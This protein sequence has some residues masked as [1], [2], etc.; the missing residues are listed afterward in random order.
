MIAYV[1]MGA[2]GS[3]EDNG[4]VLLDWHAALTQTCKVSKSR[5]YM[6][7][8]TSTKETPAERNAVNKVLLASST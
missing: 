7:S 3:K 6:R 2:I 8:N 5:R 4:S 1:T